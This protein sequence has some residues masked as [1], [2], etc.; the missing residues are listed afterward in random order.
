ML[1]PPQLQPVRVIK[2]SRHGNVLMLVDDNGDT[3][4]VDA[5][6]TAKMLAE[7]V[8]EE[9]TSGRAAQSAK[10]SLFDVVSGGIRDRLVGPPKP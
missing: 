10:A 4:I 3:Y 7:T 8:R 6:A 5:L 2:D 9:V 1:E